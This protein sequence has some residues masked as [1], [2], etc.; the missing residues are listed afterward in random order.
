NCMLNLS[1]AQRAGACGAR[2]RALQVWVWPLFV[3]RSA[4]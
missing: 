3:A 4:A 1:M 2:R